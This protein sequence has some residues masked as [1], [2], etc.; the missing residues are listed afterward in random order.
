MKDRQETEQQQTD[1]SATEHLIQGIEATATKAERFNHDLSRIISSINMLSLNAL[2]EAANSGVAGKGFGVVAQ[3]MKKLAE[4]IRVASD[5]FTNDVIHSLSARAAESRSIDQTVVGSRF[6]DLALNMIDLIDRNLYER[7]CDV[8]WWATDAAVVGAEE[9]PE[10]AAKRLGV[11]LDSY[12]VYHD[13][14][15]VRPDGT[16]LANG[17]PE[18]FKVQGKFVGEERWFAEAMATK[19][20]SDYCVGD[21][22]ANDLLEGGIAIPYATAVREGGEEQGKI[23]GV[24]VVHMNW[25]DLA[26]G[27]IAGVRL[28][29]AERGNTECFVLAESGLII[30]PSD[31]PG[32]LKEHIK[33]DWSQPQGYQSDARALIAHAHT[34]GYETYKGLGWKAM[35]RQNKK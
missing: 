31:H 8:R 17:R 32:F 30:A 24:I 25:A 2:I 10:L 9:D 3:E 7:T 27:A 12:T 19:S 14:W 15:L 29:E 11:I 18:K 23:T 13:L 33:F 22:S 5:N 35:I 21:V 4:T 6:A 28:S 20:G 16:I 26:D 34:P 1:G